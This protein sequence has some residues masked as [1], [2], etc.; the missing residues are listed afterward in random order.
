MFP[1]F[2]CACIYQSSKYTES[3]AESEA[4]T[5]TV[6]DTFDANQKS[7]NELTINFG[8]AVKALNKADVTVEKI[9]VLN[10][11]DYFTKMTVKNVSLN[12]AKDAA[13][14][15]LFNAMEDGTNYRISIKGF[16]ESYVLSATAGK[17]ESIVVTAWVGDKQVDILTTGEEAV[18]KC[19]FFDANGVDVSAA[20]Y[21]VTY[22]LVEYSK[23]GGYTLS[24]SKLKIKKAGEFVGVKA[25][26]AG[27]L[28]KG[29]MVGEIADTFYFTA[30]D[31]TPIYAVGV[32]DYSTNEF[33]S[34]GNAQDIQVKEKNSKSLSVKVTTD[35]GKTTEKGL[36]A[37]ADLPTYVGANV[38]Q[39]LSFTAVNPEI[40][41][42]TSEGKLMPYKEGY[43]TFYVNAVTPQGNGKPNLVEPFAEV[44]VT[45]KKDATFNNF[46]LDKYDV[47]VGVVDG[48]DEETIVLSAVDT[49]GVSLDITKAEIEGV[50]ENAKAVLAK[51]K[52]VITVEKSETDKQNIKIYGKKLLEA[53]NAI[54]DYKLKENQGEAAYL[55][56]KVKSNN[57]EQYFNVLVQDEGAEEDRYVSVTNG[58]YVP[59]EDEKVSVAADALRVKTNDGKTAKTKVLTF[60]A[61][62]MSGSIK[63]GKQNFIAYPADVTTA[64]AGQ[65]FYKVTKDGKDV[66]SEYKGSSVE[67]TLSGLSKAVSGSAIAGSKTVNYKDTGAG[68]YTFE[69]YYTYNA[70]ELTMVDSSTCVVNLG[71]KGA[72]SL[73]S[74]TAN[75]VKLTRDYQIN[76]N[77]FCG[78]DKAA[79]A[80][81]FTFNGRDGKKIEDMSK[82]L[83][84]VEYDATNGTG[85][86]YVESV[87]FYEEVATGEYVEYVVPVN[88]VLVRK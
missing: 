71:D 46:S 62:L 31:K 68:E 18:L 45:V 88:T 53:L 7:L 72:Y 52:D 33:A 56:F 58:V 6:V 76:S 13:T 85:S 42:I 79:I 1:I 17:P 27:W 39:T 22:S 12:D 80:A 74:Q 3:T 54:D 38:K 29:K 5:V 61:Y 57:Y 32:A 44:V 35:D 83:Y 2:A 69:L 28:E 50:S 41:S 26:Y 11:K 67:I 55:E 63:V 36:T 23:N 66:A 84:D 75:S 48:Y 59:G 51:N 82:V 9:R 10:N 30:D 40:C 65:Y 78:T 87:H 25:K 8:A 15:T 47:T 16:E 21:K 81:C 49:Y 24:G 77:E 34:S 70:G 43:A 60:D 73:A 4:V 19:Q 86:V 14:V 20:G 37:K 64:T